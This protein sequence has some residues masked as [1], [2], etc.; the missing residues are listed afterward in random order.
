MCFILYGSIELQIKTANQ[1][2]KSLTKVSVRGCITNGTLVFF[3]FAYNLVQPLGK[4][5]DI[6]VE[7]MHSI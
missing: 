2:N 4:Q 3:R 7:D 6:R 5:L 1:K